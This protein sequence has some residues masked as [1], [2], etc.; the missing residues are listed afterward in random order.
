MLEGI[1]N[2]LK[3]YR[4][5]ESMIDE[6]C[7][8]IM[9][10]SLTPDVK[11]NEIRRIDNANIRERIRRLT[12]LTDLE[13]TLKCLDVTKKSE[14]YVLEINSFVL[15][16]EKG[17]LDETIEFF[18]QKPDKE[19]RRIIHEVLKK[20]LEFSYV[21]KMDDFDKLAVWPYFKA[22]QTNNP[23]NSANIFCKVI[24]K[25]KNSASFA[26][27]MDW[28]DIVESKYL[29]E[30]L[31]LLDMYKDCHI[32]KVIDALMGVPRGLQR[33]RCIDEF[34]TKRAYREIKKGLDPGVICGLKQVN[35][36]RNEVENYVD[37]EV[38]EHLTYDDINLVN[39]TRRFIYQIHENRSP[40]GRGRIINGFYDELKR[41]ASQGNNYKEKINSLRQYCHEVRTQLKNRAEELMVVNYA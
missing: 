28:L 18:E 6:A 4:L 2:G 38:N 12:E 5:T 26:K 30:N 17:Y 25:Y 7:K 31:Q 16:A 40:L 9:K 22:F 20:N 24:D 37:E 10:S 41:A 19:Y 33:T 13:T 21:K 29:D 14:L 23:R 11:E 39:N 35:E 36:G 32:E 3:V 8:H 34:L 15:A 27:A 1:L